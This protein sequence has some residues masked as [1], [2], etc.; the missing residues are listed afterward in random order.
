MLGSHPSAV[1]KQVWPQRGDCTA[2]RTRR[3]TK[4]GGSPASTCAT[5][6]RTATPT[7]NAHTHEQCATYLADQE[8]DLLAPQELAL[9][10][11]LLQQAVVDAEELQHAVLPDVRVELDRQLP[12]KRSRDAQETHVCAGCLGRV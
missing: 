4:E 2:E 11:I 7:H 1:R 5:G 9:R 8:L 10:R 3:G 12:G 6:Q